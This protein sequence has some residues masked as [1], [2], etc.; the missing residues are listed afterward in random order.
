MLPIVIINNENNLDN[1]SSSKIEEKKHDFVFKEGEQ[2]I[3]CNCTRA[4]IL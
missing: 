1:I 4:E 2:A 3:S